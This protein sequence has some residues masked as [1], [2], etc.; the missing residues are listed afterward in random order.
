MLIVG[1]PALFMAFYEPGKNLTQHENI[2][3]RT[4]TA[5]V[6]PPPSSPE[7]SPQENETGNNETGDPTEDPEENVEELISRTD[8]ELKRRG[9]EPLSEELKCR[10]RAQRNGLD[11]GA[12]AAIATK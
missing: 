9:R 6:Q 12:C 3:S 4:A 1:F 7:A 11:P 10:F 2:I 5:I 8:D